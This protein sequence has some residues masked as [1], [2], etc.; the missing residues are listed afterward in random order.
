MKEKRECDPAHAHQNVSD[1]KPISY[2]LNVSCI[3]ICVSST[4][5]NLHQNGN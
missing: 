3:G 5:E 1:K 4:F 2:K